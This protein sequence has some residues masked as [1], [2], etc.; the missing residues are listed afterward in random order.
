MF[1]LVGNMPTLLPCFFSYGY[2]TMVKYY[3][4]VFLIVKEQSPLLEEMQIYLI[5]IYLVL[6]FICLTKVVFAR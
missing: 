6:I 5:S 3:I 4:Q 1:L 2:V